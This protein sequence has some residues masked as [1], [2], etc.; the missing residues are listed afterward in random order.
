MTAY[1]KNSRIQQVIDADC[2]DSRDGSVVRG[3]D[4]LLVATG[5]KSAGDAIQP[6]LKPR[7]RCLEEAFVFPWR[8]GFL[9]PYEG[10]FETLARD[11]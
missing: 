10:F 5:K 8:G 7:S 6:L 11:F 2:K 9:R 1:H 3:A 4:R